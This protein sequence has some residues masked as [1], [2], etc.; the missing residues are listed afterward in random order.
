MKQLSRSN[1]GAG[2]ITFHS[3]SRPYRHEEMDASTDRME[4]FAGD[5]GYRI[6]LHNSHDIYLNDIRKTKSENLK[7]VI[8]FPVV[9]KDPIHS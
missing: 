3:R 4:A 2:A 7:T 8:R 9:R 1:V 6:L 5:Q